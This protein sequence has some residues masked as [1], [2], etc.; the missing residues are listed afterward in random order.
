MINT[1]T[2]L[3]LFQC[4][5]EFLSQ[6]FLLSIPGPVIG[7]LLLLLYLS[8]P[9]QYRQAQL[10]LESEH[11]IQSILQHLSLLFVPAGVGVMLHLDQL[12]NDGF[13]L[14]VALVLSTGLGLLATAHT[15]KFFMDKLKLSDE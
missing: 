9:S 6:S 7:M 13:A 2:M 1:I 5:G 14:I 8:W 10:P 11:H 3:L 12:L 4:I 15:V